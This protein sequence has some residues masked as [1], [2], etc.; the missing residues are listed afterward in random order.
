MRIYIRLDFWLEHRE[1]L[2]AFL[3]SLRMG[4]PALNIGRKDADSFDGVEQRE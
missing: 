3:R 4:E 1:Q 2:L